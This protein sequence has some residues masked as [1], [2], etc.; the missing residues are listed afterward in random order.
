MDENDDRDQ[1]RLPEGAKSIDDRFT[2]LLRV[3]F[4]WV[5]ACLGFVVLK[6]ALSSLSSNHLEEDLIITFAGPITFCLMQP[7]AG[8]SIGGLLLGTAVCWLFIFCLAFA[9]AKNKQMK[10][11][12]AT[13]SLSAILVVWFGFGQLCFYAL[14]SL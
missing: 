11:E 6:Q 8:G 14:R 1:R 2:N 3:I 7:G 13:V 10:L 5:M 9:L 4:I 12:T